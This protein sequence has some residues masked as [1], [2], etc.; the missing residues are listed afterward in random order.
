MTTQTFLICTS[1]CK[2][3]QGEE[4]REVIWMQEDCIAA[5]GEMDEEEILSRCRVPRA[6]FSGLGQPGQLN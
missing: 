5:A 6:G 4:I 1:S 2:R 3:L